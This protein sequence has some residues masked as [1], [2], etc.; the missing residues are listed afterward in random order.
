MEWTGGCLCGAVAYRATGQPLDVVSCHC[1]Y[2]RKMSG[3]AFAT[4]VVFSPEQFQ[5]ISGEIATYTATSDY[6]R[7][8]CKNC[9]SS[10]ASWRLSEQDRW[11]APW[12][13]S[14]DQAELLNPCQHIFAKD[15][16]PWL[17]MDD[18]LPRYEKFAEKVLESLGLESTT[19]SKESE[20]N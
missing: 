12:A 10:V 2:C 3:A 16:L 19:R 6:Q 8:F 17:H 20:D 5:W 9:G 18:G 14:L 4:C 13:G 11:I 15:E 1:I 7:G